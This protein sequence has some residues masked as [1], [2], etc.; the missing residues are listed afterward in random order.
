MGYNPH[1]DKVIS[2]NDILIADGHFSS[3]TKEL[4]P[5]PNF[6]VVGLQQKKGFTFVTYC[7]HRKGWLFY[8]PLHM[9]IIFYYSI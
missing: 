7:K 6:S 5:G 3:T 8:V 2:S 1:F 4:D 9:Y